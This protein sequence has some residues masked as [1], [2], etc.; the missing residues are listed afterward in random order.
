VK[1]KIIDFKNLTLKEF[2]AIVSKKLKEHKLDCTL[3]G[4]ACVSIYSHN[5]YQS[6]DLG[7]VKK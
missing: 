1:E 7:T 2:A 4:G 3:V 5:R 6:F